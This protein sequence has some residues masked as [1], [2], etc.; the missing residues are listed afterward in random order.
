MPLIT[1]RICTNLFAN[2][3]KT[4]HRSRGKYGTHCSVGIWDEGD[5]YLD[6]VVVGKGAIVV[7][8]YLWWDVV[9]GVAG[10]EDA[11]KGSRRGTEG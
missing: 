11:P 8:S 7:S 2:S 9:H 5:C 1:K 10:L 4:P 3:G 6:V